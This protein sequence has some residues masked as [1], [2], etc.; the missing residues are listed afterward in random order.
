M[1]NSES[2]PYRAILRRVGYVF[3]A[4]CLLDIGYTIYRIAHQTFHFPT[5]AILA[6][7][8]GIMLIRGHLGTARVLSWFAALLFAGFMSLL[9]LLV[10]YFPP[11]LMRAEFRDAPGEAGILFA[12]LALLTALSIWLYWQLTSRSV[13]EARIAAGKHVYAERWIPALTTASFAVMVGALHVMQHTDAAAKAREL[14][15]AKLGPGYKY[16]VESMHWDWGRD[17]AR[18]TVKAYNDTQTTSVDV[19]WQPS[20]QGK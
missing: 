11:D 5:T 14:A 3:L 2:A 4:V 17:Q 15:Q 7:F 9:V 13:I 8:V 16:F 20:T 18:A 6:A 12:T 10:T 1:A 19:E